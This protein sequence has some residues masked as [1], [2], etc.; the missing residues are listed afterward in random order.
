MA[1]WVVLAAWLAACGDVSVSE[2]PGPGDAD[3][4]HVVRRD[5]L[6]AGDQ[7]V[8]ARLEGHAR[9]RLRSVQVERATVG[10]RH[11]PLR[12][13]DHP[14]DA[15]HRPDLDHAVNLLDLEGAAANKAK[16]IAQRLWND[17][18]AGTVNGSPHTI[19]STIHSRDGTAGSIPPV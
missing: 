13:R 10:N 2:N 18:P 15:R 7:Q 17:D 5:G 1:Q 3:D 6:H 4:P 19:E 11:R 8:A 9:R 14:D 16:P 12:S